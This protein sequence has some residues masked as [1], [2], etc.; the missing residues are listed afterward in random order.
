[1]VGRTDGQGNYATSVE[2]WVM[3]NGLFV[4]APIDQN[5]NPIVST[6][7]TANAPRLLATI[8][9]SSFQASQTYYD[10]VM[11]SLSRNAIQRTF[12]ISNTLNE[13]V[14]VANI[15]PTDS[16]VDSNGGN[17]F[18]DGTGQMANAIPSNSFGLY[19]SEVHPILAAHVD[20]FQIG[21]SMGSTAPTSGNVKIYVV[22]LI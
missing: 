20:S 16:T 1:M 21:L 8:Q 18:G 2:Q 19:T 14:T 17:D 4:P 22:E 15:L 9:Y 10:D 12:I 3:F 11:E 6:P 13:P 7:K 5:G